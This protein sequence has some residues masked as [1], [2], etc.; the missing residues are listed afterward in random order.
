MNK[1]SILIGVLL[2]TGCPNK[3]NNQ[4]VFPPDMPEV[5]KDIRNKQKSCFEKMT[6]ALAFAQQ[7]RDFADNAR[8]VVAGLQQGLEECNSNLAT[9]NTNLQECLNDVRNN[10]NECL[11]RADDLALRCG[12]IEDNQGNLANQCERIE[13]NQGNLVNQCQRIEDNQANQV[14][15]HVACP[16]GDIEPKAPEYINPIGYWG[17]APLNPY[18][19]EYGQQDINQSLSLSEI[20]QHSNQASNITFH[21]QPTHQVELE[22]QRNIVH[23]DIQPEPFQL[24]SRSCDLSA[25]KETRNKPTHIDLVYNPRKRTI[26][27]RRE[28][29]SS[30]SRIFQELQADPFSPEAITVMEKHHGLSSNR[31]QESSQSHF[32]LFRQPPALSESYFLPVRRPDNDLQFDVNKL[33]TVESFVIEESN[34][35]EQH[36]ERKSVNSNVNN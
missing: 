13:D 33:D 36:E 17:A 15:I 24:S 7:A 29:Q 2:L 4:V 14:S 20:S 12:R 11:L 5:M 1:L 27:T 21:L 34:E 32:E 16:H 28:F 8:V 35:H 22:G 26:Q 23:V 19:I 31:L 9:C 18:E 10:Q 3:D 25:D 30:G 6:E